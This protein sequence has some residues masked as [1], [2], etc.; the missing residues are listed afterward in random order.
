[1]AKKIYV[2]DTSVYL[3]D[4]NSIKLFGNNDI[5]IPFKVLEEVDNHKKRQDSVGTNARKTIRTLDVLRENGSLYK[6]VRLGKGKGLVYVKNCESAPHNLDASVADNEI[7]AVALQEREKNPKRKVIVCFTRHQH[8]RK[9]RCARFIYRRLHYKSSSERYRA[10]IF[11][12]WDT[13]NG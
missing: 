3:T 8:A 12:H 2:L 11:R 5:I 13:F 6:G 9:M 4:A 7:I 1:M 10:F